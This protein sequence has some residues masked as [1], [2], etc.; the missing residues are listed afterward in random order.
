MLLKKIIKN[1]PI[2]IQKIN[3]K[4][5]S[6]DSR[7]IKK[8]YL[9]FAVKGMES[10]GE[11]YIVSAIRKGASA[12]VCET[13]SKV[14]NNKIPIIKVKNIKKTMTDACIVFYKKKPKNIIA[15]TGTNGKSS[16]AEFYHQILAAQ[17]IPVASIG[18]LGIKI[19]TKAIKTNLTTLDIISL[20]KNLVKIKMLGIDNVILEASSHGLEQ[21]RL[22]G[23]NF[24]TAI[25]TNF[26]QD[27]LDYHKNMKNYLNAKLILFSKLLKKKQNIITDSEI[28]EFLNLKKIAK[29]NNLNL[30]TIGKK[31][32][33]I[34]FKSVKFNDNFQNIDFSHNRK[35]Y[36]IK[37]PLIGFFQIKNLFMSILASKLSGVDI[38]KSIYVTKNI[39][40]VNGR[41][42]LIK[43]TPNQTKI[44]IDYAHTP[45]A[46]E[47]IL[48]TLKEHY[49]IKPDV[50]FGCGGDRDQK[51][52][53]KMAS[54]CENNAE[55]IYITDDNARN[56]NPKQIRRM[57][58]SGFSKKLTFTE[59]PSRPVAIETAIIKSKPN[60]VILIAGKGHE[61]TQTYGNKIINISDKE[62]V[63]LINNKKLRFDKR[64][65]NKYINAK[66]IKKIIKKNK[67]RFEG[68]SIN[69]KQTKKNN[70]F[71]A[72]KGKNYDGHSFVKEALKNKA[73]YCVVQKNI[74]KIDKKK[75]I[76]Y[77][78]T[79]NFLNKLAILKRSHSD[80]KVIA[81]TGSSGK[82]TLKSMLGKTLSAYGK[83]Y[84]SQKSYNNHIGVPFSLC[85]LEN[86]HQYSVFE[87]GMS[88][89]GEIRKLS[90]L[91]KPNIAIITNIGEAHLENFNNLNGIAK[92]KS[93]IIENINKDGYL[94][95]NR[96]DRYFN[97]LL[98]FA[99]K[100]KIKVLSF[101]KSKKSN[102]RLIKKKL[103]KNYSYLH[104]RVLNKNIYLKV[105]N[106]NP[107][108]ISNILFILL[109]LQALGL[110]IIKVKNCSNYF[111]L[112]EGRGKEHLISRYK[113]KFQLIDESYNANPS[114]VKNAINNFSNLK[115]KKGRKFL[116]LGDM[117]ELGKKSDNYHKN[118]AYF[119]NRSDIDKLF[120][121]GKNAF[122]TY[123]K[124]YKAKQGNILQNLND[125]DEIF[126]D[127]I[128]KDDY[129]MIKGSNATGLNKLSKII[130]LGNKHAL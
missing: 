69:S 17:K 119:I 44:F 4:E 65:Y 79:I 2:N 61:T 9:F 112:A 38:K 48:K 24:K 80:S 89:A 105:K 35:T 57:I 32:S 99:R 37:I 111:Q 30:L 92:A 55:K 36:A 97:Y 116:L 98:K 42:Q 76:N 68:V 10:N 39:K 121:Y 82:T 41:L 1:L 29:K 87:I 23:I 126:S 70:L 50:V 5:L 49:K 109:T 102:A 94:I 123:Q 128:N 127:I 72:I 13:G 11:D 15:I 125:F 66:I 12:V 130:I 104:F 107:L 71:V 90:K 18:T 58:I 53:S 27:H 8:N 64:N 16:V 31:N 77:P 59:I 86:N 83:T 110:N 52:R 62:I 25:F 88:N 40:E 74:K 93:E 21:G 118:L 45:N 91:V 6:L 20:H 22:N 63:R 85:N 96:E 46:L 51:K 124:T 106:V 108:T 81:I 78:N 120:V 75:L 100:R 129:L 114:S 113:K 115:R 84:F 28:P 7:K 33:T 122:K 73:N 117:L 26:S 60:S 101:G 56:E 14:K 3:I 54:V 19:N 67:L 95:L 43:T 47:T 103:Y 34:Q